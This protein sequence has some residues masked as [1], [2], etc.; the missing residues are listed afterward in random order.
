MGHYRSWL[1]REGRGQHLPYDMLWFDVAGQTPCSHRVFPLGEPSLAVRRH[2]EADGRVLHSEIVVCSQYTRASWH[3]MRA[4]EQLIALRLK[5]ESAASSVGLDPVDYCDLPLQSLP[6]HLAAG[7]DQTRRLA[8]TRA[9]PVEIAQSLAGDLM[10]TTK[11]SRTAT[12]CELAAAALRRCEGAVPISRLSI[13]LD[14]NP[15]SLRRKFQDCLGVSPKFYARRLRL[16]RAA[17]LADQS[18]PVW[19]DIASLCGFH[20]QAHLIRDYQQ[21][22]GLTPGQSHRERMGLAVFSNTD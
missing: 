7:F 11:R 19:A 10:R 17:R 6:R 5:P 20:D 13:A 4:G 22:V 12:G 16:A 15:R 14:L 1:V 9:S 2:L 3:R 18:M 8:E 21:L